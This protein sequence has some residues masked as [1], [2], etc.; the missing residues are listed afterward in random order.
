MKT[1]RG[2]YWATLFIEVEF[3]A[4]D[5]KDANDIMDRYPCNKG[6]IQFKEV[7]G[8][9]ERSEYEVTEAPPILNAEVRDLKIEIG[10]HTATIAELINVAAGLECDLAFG[11]EYLNRFPIDK[12]P[13]ADELAMWIDETGDY[14]DFI[15]A[16]QQR[17]L[18]DLMGRIQS[19]V[20][21]AKLKQAA[22]SM[23]VAVMDIEVPVTPVEPQR[24]PVAVSDDDEGGECIICG[25]KTYHEGIHEDLCGDCSEV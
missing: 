12:K 11:T 10:G 13:S 21:I 4:T 24:L 1:Y 2:K 5:L 3:E 23:G 14:G 19:E 25:E 22:E 6:D 15:D 18:L 17:S 7:N 8:I 16:D 9:E 20:V